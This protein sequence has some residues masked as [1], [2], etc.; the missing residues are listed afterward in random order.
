MSEE[1]KPRL[2]TIGALSRAS[3]VPPDTLRTWER[4]YGFPKPERTDTGHRRYAQA[5]LERLQLV[6]EALQHGHRAA[7]VIHADTAELRNLIE[8]ARVAEPPD[9]DSRD[10][11]RVIERWIELVRRFDGRSLERELGASLAALGVPSFLR[12]RAAPFIKALGDR[13]ADGLLGVRHEHFAS[14]RLTEFFARQWRPLSDGANGPAVV[15]ATPAGERHALGLQMVAFT[16]A[17]NNLRVVY[18]GADLPAQ[19]IAEAV[20][21]HAARALVLSAAVG[22]DTARVAAEVSTLRAALGDAFPILA[23]GCG[24]RSIEQVLIIEDFAA[25]EGWFA[26]F[27]AELV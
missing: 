21:Q 20:T 12:S 1:L 16:L 7:A 24:F 6:R 9:E 26:N 15:C 17:L 19:E 18:L 2:F 11:A 22:V 3:G 23:G 14:E 25:L 8:L 4:R 10:T 5:T 27:A 13:W